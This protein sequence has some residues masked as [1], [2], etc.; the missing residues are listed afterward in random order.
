MRELRRRGVRYSGIIVNVFR[1][2]NIVAV[3]LLK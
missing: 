2:R 3:L 1:G